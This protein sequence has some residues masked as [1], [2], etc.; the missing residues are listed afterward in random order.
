MGNAS[1]GIVLPGQVQGVKQ[2]PGI[3]IAPDG[4]I[5]VNSQ[6]VV[7]LM[8]MG[9]TIGTATAAYNSYEWPLGPGL[10]GMVVKIDSTIGGVTKL[11][12]DT[13]AGFTNKGQLLV[14]TGAGTDTLLNVG[15][16]GTILIADSTTVSGLNYTSNYVATTDAQGAANIP[17]G[18]TAQ[19][20]ASPALGA[21]RFNDTLDALEFWN[22]TAWEIV[23]SSDVNGFV[24]KTSDTGSA[25]IPA[26]TTAQRDTTPFAGFF[27]YNNTTGNLEYFDGVIWKSVSASATG[28]FVPQSVPN[29]GTPSAEIPVGS[30][31]Q[32][33]SFPGTG[34]LRYNSDIQAL[35]VW[36][37][38]TWDNTSGEVNTLSFGT[39]GLIPNTPTVGDIIV[40]G[41]L[42]I[43]N[44]GTSA[45]N[46]PQAINNLLPVQTGNN[47]FYL[48]TN[49]TQPSW[50]APPSM[51]NTFS[52]GVTGFNP[53][54]ATS[55]IVTLTGTL[56]LQSG[57][58]GATTQPGA[59]NAIL[60]AQG[61][62]SGRFLSTDGSN[63]TWSPISPAVNSF[64]AGVTGFTP[65][66]A[67]TGAIILGGT[68]NI[69]SGGTN[70]NTRNS[71]LNNLLPAQG[72]S[73]TYTLTTD[74]SNASWQPAGGSSGGAATLA[75]A[76]AGVLTTVYS[77]PQTAVPK[78]SGGMVGA[79]ILPGGLPGLRP[80]GA[81]N[82]YFRHNPQQ[83]NQVILPGTFV[84]YYDANTSTWQQLISWSQAK[85]ISIDV[86]GQTIAGF[87]APDVPYIPG[88]IPGCVIT[89]PAGYSQ[90]FV[91]GSLSWSF[92]ADTLLGAPSA[93]QLITA[94]GASCA[95]NAVGPGDNSNMYGLKIGSSAPG[96]FTGSPTVS[97][98]FQQELNKSNFNN[99]QCS[100]ADANLSV[101]A[102]RPL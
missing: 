10:P 81:T 50:Q 68:L 61:G 8:K 7:G 22:G 79:A 20:P 17:A 75:Q 83:V 18:I 58:T 55:G 52:A 74:G 91:V 49:G 37:G 64:S 96:A 32:R 11:K 99:G 40:S 71:A 46:A 41:I 25:I 15:P 30:T 59:A 29:S 77:S 42:N 101:L 34:F 92:F 48:V 14:G 88:F 53:A 36:N 28:S 56:N 43:S 1:Q 95:Y 23:A 69:A 86:Y 5:S 12:W 66:V 78:D 72:G 9:Q 27:R 4:T 100:P 57:G 85:G 82:G 54:V 80:G 6:T 26:G 90:F 65:A 47:G 16:N 93:Q 89:V 13:A 31:A 2:G 3:S 44:G 21:F 39:T 98:T 24:E 102:W 19:R 76:A 60:P 97:Y 73:A 87:F 33:Q 62:N 51:V 94:N 84:E 45:D 63:V 67:T 35:E 38:T 70:A